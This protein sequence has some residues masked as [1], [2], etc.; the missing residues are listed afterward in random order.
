M[1]IAFEPVF[2]TVA[3]VPEPDGVTED[4]KAFTCSDSLSRSRTAFC[5][6]ALPTACCEAIEAIETAPSDTSDIATAAMT[7]GFIQ[8]KG[9]CA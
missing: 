9:Y 6:L 7:T 1:V 4:M 5:R 3:T 8:R 2:L